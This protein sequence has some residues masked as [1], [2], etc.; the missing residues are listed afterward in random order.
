MDPTAPS[1]AMPFVKPEPNVSQ[2]PRAVTRRTS[3][4]SEHVLPSRLAY[5]SLNLLVERRLT[6]DTGDVSPTRLTEVEEHDPGLSKAIQEILLHDEWALQRIE[7]IK[8][9]VDK[10]LG[11]AELDA[12]KLRNRAEADAHKSNTTG[13][14]R[15]MSIMVKMV[16]KKEWPPAWRFTTTPSRDLVRSMPTPST[17]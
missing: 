8:A 12:R 6:F 3:F 9:S 17:Q 13:K 5:S 1:A 16:G 2:P 15:T 11:D 7:Q 4:R 10:A 14:H